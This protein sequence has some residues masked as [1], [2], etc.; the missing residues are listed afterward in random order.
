V[1]LTAAVLVGVQALGNLLVVAAL[2]APAVAARAVTRRVPPLIA[3][4]C[5]LGVVCGIGGLYV[6]Y[7]ADIAAG[8]AIA[9]LLVLSAA[10]TASAHA[11]VLRLLRERGPYQA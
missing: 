4:S 6:S 3:V 10:L 9:G 7:Y 8:A 11:V 2:I 5:T 1:L